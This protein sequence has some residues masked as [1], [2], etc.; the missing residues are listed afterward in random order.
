MRD[1]L[2]IYVYTP[3]SVYF[4]HEESLKTR[5]LF[6]LHALSQRYLLAQLKYRLHVQLL[7]CMCQLYYN[8]NLTMMLA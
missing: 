4:V 6:M 1:V 8:Q 3:S 2:H 7:A 5:G